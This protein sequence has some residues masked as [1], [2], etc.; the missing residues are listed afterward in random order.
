MNSGEKEKKMERLISY[1]I[2]EWVL[3][4][5]LRGPSSVRAAH[6]LG[7]H[8]ISLELGSAEEGFPLADDYIIQLYQ[9]EQGR[10]NITFPALACNMTDHFAMT[11]PRGTPERDMVE[12]ALRLSISAAERLRIPVVQIPSFLSSA[13]RSEDEL[14][15]AAECLRY[16][17]DLASGSG[18]I[19]G[20]ENC[21]TTEWQMR[22]MELVARDNFKVYFDTQNY[23][24]QTGTYAPDVAER[25]FPYIVQVHLKDGIG[26][27]GNTLIGAGESDA[28]KSVDRL[29]ERGYSG[30]MIFENNYFTPPLASG[31]R[32]SYELIKEDL[33]AV[34][35]YV[36]DCRG[37]YSF[38]RGAE[39]T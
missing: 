2:C 38:H 27:G 1:G 30:W 39:E 22:E 24:L 35:K 9:E 5:R 25:L 37:R 6:D 4:A 8:G 29:M 19:I 14:R 12:Y 31:G 10:Y 18:I 33:A 16:A 34:S 21:L 11:A 23:H 36:E 28:L 7:L 17:C 32:D 15:Q 3:P 13:I 26:Q 20:T